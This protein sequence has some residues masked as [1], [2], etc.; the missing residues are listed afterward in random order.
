[1]DEGRPE[2]APTRTAPVSM[3]ATT[4]T[5][6]VAPP[7]GPRVPTPELDAGAAA[8]PQPPLAPTQPTGTQ[9][10]NPGG[11][12][13]IKAK[14]SARALELKSAGKSDQEILQTLQSE[15]YRVVP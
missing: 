7:V 5:A 2:L 12:N 6:T 14:A 8:S 10:F 13:A 11:F 1:M 9:P 4:R 15:G 3:P